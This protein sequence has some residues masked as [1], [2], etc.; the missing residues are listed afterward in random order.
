[1]ISECRVLCIYL[2]F[3]LN[4][5]WYCLPDSLYTYVLIHT[6]H[7]HTPTHTHTHRKGSRKIWNCSF[8]NTHADTFRNNPCIILI[9]RRQYRKGHRHIETLHTD[10]RICRANACTRSVFH[11]T[12]DTLPAHKHRRR[13][14]VC[15]C[16][17]VCH[18]SK[19]LCR[20]AGSPGTARQLRDHLHQPAV[21]VSSCGL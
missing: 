9:S 7:T 8:T 3:P 5:C 15:V 13:M 19:W 21:K 1:M 11:I 17:C 16:V 18:Q 2:S 6:S 4:P 10:T 20:A 12:K 14:C